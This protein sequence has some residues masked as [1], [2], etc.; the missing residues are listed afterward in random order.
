MTQEMQM[1]NAKRNIR[2]TCHIGLSEAEREE[3]EAGIPRKMA[4]SSFFKQA[5][6][7]KLES[8][9]KQKGNL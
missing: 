8:M 9:N 4:I 2:H 6:F 1:S 3:V 7:E 5:G